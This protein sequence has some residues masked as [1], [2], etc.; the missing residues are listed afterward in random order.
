MTCKPPCKHEFCW[1]CLG[2][3]NTHDSKA[4]NGYKETVRRG[5]CEVVRLRASAQEYIKRYA[6]YYERWAANEKSREKALA[7]L[8]EIK[9]KKL[10]KLEKK[11]CQR[12]EHLSFV[13]EAWEQIVECRRVLKWTYVYGYYMPP[14]AYMKTELFEYLQGEAEVA[15]ERLHDYA[16][17]KLQKYFRDEANSEEFNKVFRM[18][19]TNLTKVTRRFFSNFLKGLEHELS[20]VDVTLVEEK[21]VQLTDA[22]RCQYCTALND[23]DHN[24]CYGCLVPKRGQKRDTI[25]EF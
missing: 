11:H 2:P 15:L 16:E 24:M 14:E 4:C 6:H 8:S 23:G 5:E 13:T 17:N 7:D 19:L 12:G 20:E 1:I 9:N 22:W 25:R 21:H 18:E 3:W 10:Q